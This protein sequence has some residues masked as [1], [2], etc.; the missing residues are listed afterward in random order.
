MLRNYSSYHVSYRGISPLVP[1]N[2]LGGHRPP[3]YRS[4]NF[5]KFR[6]ALYCPR[7]YNPAPPPLPKSDIS[8]N[9]PR[10]RD[11]VLR[12]GRAVQ[13]SRLSLG[14]H[15]GLRPR[16]ILEEAVRDGVLWFLVSYWDCLN[17]DWIPHY[18]RA[19]LTD[20]PDPPNVLPEVDEVLDRVPALTPVSWV[21]RFLDF[22]VG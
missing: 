8:C 9:C 22:L 21:W 7:S 14:I 11:W 6:A 5:R 17:P 1:F 4:V 3:V 12:E 15:Y 10:C 16:Q 20:W 18:L 13:L 2:C 19:S